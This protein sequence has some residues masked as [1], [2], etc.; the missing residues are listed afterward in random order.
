VLFL[1]R[2][3]IPQKRVDLL[4]QIW[5]KLHKKTSHWK[6]WVVR[7]GE[8]R[9]KTEAFC[10][11]HKLD[12]VIFFGKNNYNEYYKRAKIFHM[13]SICEGFGNVL[14][15]AQTFGCVPMLFNS[16]VAGQDIVIHNE[17]GILIPPFNIDKMADEIAKLAKDQKKQNKMMQSSL[18]RAHDFHLDNVGKL[19]IDFFDRELKN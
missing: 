5:E 1:G 11:A 10:K 8:E 14:V 16:H 6:F 9:N 18:E 15:E 3:N 4:L 17:T 19:W 13:I 12:R 2:L 7:H